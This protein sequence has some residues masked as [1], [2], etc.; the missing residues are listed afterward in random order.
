MNILLTGSGCTETSI[1]DCRLLPGGISSQ[2]HCNPTWLAITEPG[3]P[4]FDPDE[5]LKIGGI[6]LHAGQ[7]RILRILFCNLI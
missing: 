6:V 5:A 2:S 7:V 4:I 3:A 1:S